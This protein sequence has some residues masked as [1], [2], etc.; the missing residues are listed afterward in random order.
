LSHVR[1]PWHHTVP[2]HRHTETTWGQLAAAYLVP[3]KS[4]QVK[5]PSS[6][7]RPRCH[8]YPQPQPQ[9]GWD[10]GYPPSDCAPP[11]ERYG[12]PPQPGWG[13]YGCGYPPHQGGHWGGHGYGRHM[14]WL[15]A[16]A[17]IAGAG[18]YGVYIHLHNHHGH[19]RG[20]YG[21]GYGHHGK[22][23]QGHQGKFKHYI[24]SPRWQVQ[25]AACWAG[26]GKFA[27]K[28]PVT[29]LET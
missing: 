17:A 10:G 13:G 3:P 8:G 1:L 12:Y 25:Q 6:L 22:F 9:P 20:Y 24:C 26:Q 15:A 16:G 2:Q 28:P 21:H 27:A 14:G 5:N 4:K 11:P 23:K 18:A 19:G 7:P 29:V